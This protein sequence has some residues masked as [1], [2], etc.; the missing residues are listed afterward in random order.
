M[1]GNDFAD[2][3][4]IE[5]TFAEGIQETNFTVSI[6][7][8]NL[9]EGDEI[10]NLH[11]TN[12]SPVGILGAISS[13]SITVLDDDSRIEFAAAT[14]NV[15][16]DGV[17][18]TV[19]ILRQGGVQGSA[20]VGI[21]T[22][23]NG[24][25]T[26]GSDFVATNGTITFASGV[27]NLS[28]NVT[29]LND[30][31]VEGNEN[32]ELQLANP[33]GQG[34]A[35]VV[36]GT[37]DTASLVI[38]DED[39]SEGVIGFIAT[40]FVVDEDAGTV[41]VGV[42]RTSGALGSVSVDYVTGAGT[43]LA[44][45]DYI[46]TNGTLSWVP[47]EAGTKFITVPIVDDNEV[48]G[49]QS[50]NLA[51]SNLQPSAAILA[52]SNAVVVIADNDG[53]VQ[54]VTE[55]VSVAENV[56]AVRVEVRRSGA[57]N[58]PVTVD[59]A[60]TVTGTA[61]AGQDFTPVSGTLPF[62]AGVVSNSF[63]V[64]IVDD[65]VAESA[66]TIDVR[67]ANLTGVAFLGTRTN[68]TITVFDDDISLQFQNSNFQVSEA[69]PNATITVTRLGAT[70][71]PVSIDYST[72]DGSAAAGSDYVAQ[73]GT[74][75]FAAGE[76]VKTFTISV[77]G[78]AI[79]ETDELLN[80][81]LDLP[82]GA[83]KGTP[84]TATLTILNDDTDVEFLPPDPV[85]EGNTNRI[86]EVRRRGVATN[87]F[88]VNFATSDGSATAGVD[89]VSTNGTLSFNP[90]ET[91]KSFA[92]AILDNAVATGDR[93][94]NLTLSNPTAGVVLGPNAIDQLDI[95]D[96]E[97]ILQISAAQFSV[98]EQQS[99]VQVLI[100]RQGSTA[101]PVNFDFQ[102]SGIT[103]IEGQDVIA[104]TSTL[105]FPAGTNAVAAPIQLVDD[106]LVE[107]NKT[108]QLT[109]SNPTGGATIGALNTAVLR[110]VDNE[111]VGSID[112]EFLSAI[113]ADGNVNAVAVYK[114]G[115]TNLGKIIIAGDFLN[116][117]TSNRVRVARLFPDGTLDP[118][119]DPGLGPNNAVNA[120]AIDANDRVLL[121]G[122][123]TSYN[124]TAKPGI[125]R[126]NE[127]GSL[128]TGFNNAGAGANSAVL[129]IAI[130]G[131]GKI[132][133]GGAFT[134]Y[135]GSTAERLALLD[136]DGQMDG[137]F[138]VGG[139]A[140]DNT[141]FALE[142]DS[143]DN[144]LVGGRFD[145][146]K[147]VV[148]PSIVCLT[149]AGALDGTFAPSLAASTEIRAIELQSSGAVL[150]GGDFDAIGIQG[151]TN[152][153]RLLGNNGAVDSTFNGSATFANSLVRDL[154]VDATGRIPD[155]W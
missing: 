130:R 89:Y 25:A 113:G 27:T 63:E 123:F 74:L 70:N 41:S 101:A 105:T 60:T 82:V 11:L 150:I 61:T 148:Q 154:E 95:R 34:A 44:G 35:T 32:I 88:Q 68:Y 141:V 22:T 5:L 28:F 36:L 109:I 73:S 87:S 115:T 155:G 102:V 19:T 48:E 127:N 24:T 65:I 124:G 64:I 103:A 72:S 55:A 49:S 71:Q 37:V 53:V 104:G 92:V 80:L 6:N 142:V 40:S 122:S 76:T 18:G 137:A 4:L 143:S 100:N 52:Q 45:S 43:A 86:I 119:F 136:A 99:T 26:A 9:V 67:L 110:V 15:S 153:A 12:S 131:D 116:Y 129:A 8:D 31:E 7:N 118:S 81:S 50:F 149:G 128:D 108:V 21:Q 58:E 126:L 79:F 134:T 114:N 66:E 83:V 77:V 146:F 47:S 152:I 151:R 91:T 97:I 54:F 39:L 69:N 121:G 23:G 135:N 139:A 13:S 145:R 17:T 84:N 140:F 56:G 75:N 85:T 120:V 59:F 98:I 117:S 62:A 111:R 107:S 29:I 90:G 14:F 144:I 30:T 106:I 133:I 78:D 38:N 20:S 51:L 33:V 147:A 10:I 42:S 96:D 57:T 125:V 138:N 94:L 2:T 112:S 132:A 46:S 16:E 93:S 3:G 1:A